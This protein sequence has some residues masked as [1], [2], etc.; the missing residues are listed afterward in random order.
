MSIQKKMLVTFFTTF[1]FMLTFS[2]CAQQKRMEQ[3][4]DKN[5]KEVVV[6]ANESVA[7]LARNY[8]A[9]SDKLTAEQK[10]K[11]LAVQEKFYQQNQTLKEEIEK[12]R[13]VLI[14]TVLEPKMNERE[15]S[16]LKKKIIKLEN[17]RIN[18]SFLAVSE[19]RN[20]IGPKKEIENRE[21]YRKILNSSLHEF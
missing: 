21:Y 15:Y 7:E 17:K 2:S 1:I 10:N 8:I 11:L 4:I 6:P 12:S 16:L 19:A 13:L 3:K 20:I 9:Q 18:N 14:Q 5:I